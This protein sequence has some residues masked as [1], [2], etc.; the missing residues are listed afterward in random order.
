MLTFILMSIK[1]DFSKKL[2][3]CPSV[4]LLWINCSNYL[5]DLKS[6]IIR[7]NWQWQLIVE[8]LFNWAE[9]ILFKYL[10]SSLN[11]L[12]GYLGISVYKYPANSGGG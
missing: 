1:S 4:C 2:V 6:I 12:N 11:N 5:E 8:V 9:N 10:M 7:K 3:I